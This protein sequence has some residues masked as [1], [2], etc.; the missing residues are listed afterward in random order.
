VCTYLHASHATPVVFRG[1]GKFKSIDMLCGKCH[2]AESRKSDL[3]KII[4]QKSSR[5]CHLAKVISQHGKCHLAKSRKSDFAKV[6]SQK[7]S[8]RITWLSSSTSKSRKSHLAKVKCHLAK[9]RQSHLAKVISQKS[10]RRI[11]WLSSSTSKSHKKSSRK[12]QTW[13][14]YGK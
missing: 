2:L 4:S 9:S 5:K 13:G 3:A 11:T 12:S 7:S 6:I 10:S 14:G 1:G 8:R